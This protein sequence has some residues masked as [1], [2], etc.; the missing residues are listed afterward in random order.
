MGEELGVIEVPEAGAV[1]GHGVQVAGD[2]VICHR[3][4]VVALVQGL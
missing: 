3:I 1:I 2:V 4:P